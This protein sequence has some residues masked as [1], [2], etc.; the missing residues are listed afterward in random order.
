MS[1][2]A[3]PPSSAS[4]RLAL[5]YSCLGHLFSHLFEPIF[6]VVALV[7]PR[8]LGMSYEE[9]LVLIVA[10]KL[11]Y[12]LLAPVAGWLGDRWSTTAMM[13]VYFL[14]LGAAGLGMA[15]AQGPWGIAVALAATGAFGSIYH[16]VG[17]AWLVRNAVDK[18]KAIGINGVFGGVGPAIAAVAAGVLIQQ[19]GWR[20][21]FVVP[22]GVILLVGF[23]FLCALASGRVVESRVDRAPAPAPS[24][25]D[26]M[27]AGM[28]LSITMLLG[29]LIY[30]ATQPTLP[31][32]FGERLGEGTGIGDAAMAVSA[33][34]LIAG[35]GQIVSGHLA[36]RISPRRM[37]LAV[38][39]LQA[40]F[41]LLVA[42]ATGLPVVAM[43]LLA[44][45]FNMAAIPAENI[46]LSRYTPAKWRG[47]AFGMK[48]VL[49]FGV[50]GLGVPLVSFLY[51]RTGG[52]A[53]LFALL[54]AC[55]VLVAGAAW[56]LPRDERAVTAE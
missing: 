26:T 53:V 32:L 13:A 43:S 45:A 3:A 38:Y 47:T 36:D 21:A 7:L 55:A 5:A 14:G 46:L 2:L 1:T 44:V 15:L 40:P 12:G 4:A 11:F 25:Q 37:Y 49:S 10:A 22:G 48:F 16:P 34:Y 24:R 41:L 35:L 17:I 50:S 28:V 31:K 39:A 30:Q 52:F 42:V 54:A 8:E 9:V 19:W 33:V 51:G 56:L 27:R 23:T 20:S 18:G 29:G 6:Y